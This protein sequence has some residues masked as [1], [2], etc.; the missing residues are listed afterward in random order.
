MAEMDPRGFPGR[1][2]KLSRTVVVDSYRG[3][4]RVRS[5]PKPRG[6]PRSEK[7]AYWQE[8]FREANLVAKY[9]PA[10]DRIAAAKA[11]KNT[12]WNPRD[13]QM[14]A[15]R[16]RLFSF[17]RP[18]GRKI[19]SM[20]QKV[21]V[22]EGLDIIGQL[23]GSMLA[24]GEEYWEYLLPGPEGYV[25]TSAGEGKVPVW[26]PAPAGNGG[27]VYNPP[28]LSDFPI[29]INQGDAIAEESP[30]GIF[31]ISSPASEGYSVVRLRVKEY[32]GANKSYTV[33]LMMITYDVS[34]SGA[35]IYLRDSST[36]KL[37]RFCLRWDSSLDTQRISLERFTD[38]F[39]YYDSI[40][41]CSIS[42]GNRMFFRIRDDGSQLFFD[43][44]I[45]NA[46]FLNFASIAR[47]E[48]LTEIS[49]IGLGI[50]V[51]HDVDVG[52]SAAFFHYE[53]AEL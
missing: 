29:W 13:V 30:E 38:E 53:E 16:G 5:W 48:W 7:Q 52:T 15:M 42:S 51:Y 20:A 10:E 45:E 46:G 43:Y 24:R 4:L 49:Q 25:L 11:T 37:I 34:G 41:Y 50:R 26:R 33:G 12:P 14:K 31:V 27:L 21:D 17:V 8:W 28:K 44:S 19:Y 2:E 6:K 18:D 23:P 32:P 40:K 35:G 3:I 47:N 22:S 1:K 39:N 9:A 36:S